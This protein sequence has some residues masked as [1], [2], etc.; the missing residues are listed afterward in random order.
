MRVARRNSSSCASALLH[1]PDKGELQRPSL[2]R[3]TTS[4]SM[5]RRWCSLTGTFRTGPVMARFDLRSF[6]VSV[7]LLMLAGCAEG[8]PSHLVQE[9]SPDRFT[10]CSSAPHCVS[11]QAAPDDS[12]HIAAFNYTGNA[13][14][15]R[16]VLL[17][18]LEA[19]RRATIERAEDR[20]IHA[21]FRSA[22][23]FVDDVSFI[24]Q[25]RDHTIDVKSASRIGY[26]D[27]GVNRRRVERL[28]SQ[29]QESQR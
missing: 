17:K 21:E 16:S 15:A 26:Y 28:R 10:P 25:P 22:L 14:T 13:G 27:F 23:G 3:C 24:V 11:S 29:F 1:R 5:H 9:Q 12:H 8:T 20:L 19:N 4:R 18:V 6:G 7:L 2:Q